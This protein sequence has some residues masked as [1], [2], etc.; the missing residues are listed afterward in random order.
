MIEVSASAE[1]SFFDF[2]LQI[3]TPPAIHLENT[4]QYSLIFATLI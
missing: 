1:T 2:F 3:K 4:F